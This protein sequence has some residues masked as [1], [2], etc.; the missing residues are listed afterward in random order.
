MLGI[1]IEETDYSIEEGGTLN[2]D[3]RLQFRNNQNPFTITLSAVSINTTEDLIQDLGLFINSD[4]IQVISRATAGIFST[5]VSFS[6][7]FHMYKNGV[8]LP[9]EPVSSHCCTVY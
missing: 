8:I 9:A 3:I 1:N 4:D 7:S 5:Y 2:D 6:T